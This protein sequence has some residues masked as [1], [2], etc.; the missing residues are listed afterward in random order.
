MG[1]MLRGGL[2]GTALPDRVINSIG[3]IGKWM[4][5]GKCWVVN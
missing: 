1:V 2:G 5:G 3:F 4:K